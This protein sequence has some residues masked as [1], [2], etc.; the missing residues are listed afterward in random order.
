MGG[1]RVPNHSLFAANDEKDFLSG[2]RVIA[3]LDQIGSQHL[4]TEFRRDARRFLEEFVNC[5]LSTIASRSL[6]GQGISCF[7]PANVVGVG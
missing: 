4:W 5:L 7:C 6:I 3:A 1:I 2:T